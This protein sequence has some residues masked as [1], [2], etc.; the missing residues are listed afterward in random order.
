MLY[1]ISS[2]K[3][4]PKTVI[5]NVKIASSEFSKKRALASSKENFLLM[6][7]LTLLSSPKHLL[8]D[9]CGALDGTQIHPQLSL[10]DKYVFAFYLKKKYIYISISFMIIFSA[11]AFPHVRQ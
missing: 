4:Q 9:Q 2:K 8:T 5:K 6:L 7:Y 1:R 11:Y 10:D 3:M